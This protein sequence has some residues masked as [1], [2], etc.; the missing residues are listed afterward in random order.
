MSHNSSSTSPVQQNMFCFWLR[1]LGIGLASLLLV[2][3]VVFMWPRIVSSVISVRKH[4]LKPPRLPPLL[5]LDSKPVPLTLFATTST[6]LSSY[7]TRL[8]AGS[9]HTMRRT[10]ESLSLHHGMLFCNIA[11]II[12]YRA[13]SM[14]DFGTAISWQCIH[15]CSLCTNQDQSHLNH[16]LLL[17]LYPTNELNSQWDVRE[18]CARQWYAYLLVW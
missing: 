11:L 4:I 7:L 10:L 2:S 14:Q 8:G 12:A 13:H 9:L 16:S 15:I 1:I 3:F 6:V 18:L 17:Q 5:A